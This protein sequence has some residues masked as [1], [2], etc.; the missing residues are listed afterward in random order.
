MPL[1]LQR[2]AF[3]WALLLALLAHAGLVFWPAEPFRMP[4]P[5]RLQTTQVMLDD[6]PQTD[7]ASVDGQATAPGIAT[8]PQDAAQEPGHPA[9]VDPEPP[10]SLPQSHSPSLPQPELLPDPVDQQ[11]SVITEPIEQSVRSGSLV[12]RSLEVARLE[13]ELQSRESLL[14]ERPRV[15]RITSGAQMS[16]EEALYLRQWEARVERI[17]NLNYPEEARRQNLG[18]RLRLLV[19]INA[20]G[21]IRE[22]QLLT[23]SG[24]RLLDDA[25]IRILNLAAPFAPLPE[26]VRA[27]ADVLEIIRTWQFGDGWQAN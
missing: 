19:V 9:A 7:G 18:G 22:A 21:S 4:E 13:A 15:R 23:S 16:T 17:G 5:S 12:S 10:L 24:H 1:K 20:D 8:M 27:E 2:P 6:L 14:S 25:A 26:S 3:L 11:P